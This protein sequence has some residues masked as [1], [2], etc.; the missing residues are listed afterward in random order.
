[1]PNVGQG[2]EWF[3]AN[4]PIGYKEKIDQILEEGRK[5][6][7]DMKRVFQD[8][9]TFIAYLVDKAWMIKETY[10]KLMAEL[11]RRREEIKKWEEETRKE[12]KDKEAELVRYAQELNEKAK[13][14]A[15]LDSRLSEEWGMT[16][17]ARQLWKEVV[18]SNIVSKD[19][20]LTALKT[21]KEI[22]INLSEVARV[23]REENLQG[24]VGW[25]REVKKACI[26]AS[27][28][29]AALK[30]EVSAYKMAISKLQ[31]AEKELIDKL[32]A[33]IDRYDRALMEA[34]RACAAARDLGLYIDYIRQSLRSNG[35][36]KIQDLL[37]EPAL[38]IAGTILEAVA[39]AYGDREITIPPGPKHLFPVQVTLRQIARSL[40]P[41]EAYREQ[42]KAQIKME[43]MA[44]TIAAKVS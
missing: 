30:E 2:R 14:L 11:D 32:N 10:D 3:Q 16:S 42:Q 26:Q 7:P 38:V 19:E 22:G 9:G 29:L 12:L 33:E 13:Q 5:R 4:I 15:E 1:M 23:I 27:E 25:A 24:F 17:Y 20:I 31:S 8:R 21:L 43:V 37:P 34:E 40:A 6:Y 41:V 28:E 18:Q 35:A 36:G 44:E 39:S